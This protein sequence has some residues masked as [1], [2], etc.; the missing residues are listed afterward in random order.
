[1]LSTLIRTQ[2]LLH[3]HVHGP[4]NVNQRWCPPTSGTKSELECRHHGA[5]ILMLAGMVLVDSPGLIFVS[6]ESFAHPLPLPYL[7][8]Q[9]NE[10]SQI[11][12]HSSYRRRVSA[13]LPSG[14][15]AN[16]N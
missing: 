12:A 10:P 11:C 8:M 6:T 4:V 2:Y 3:G 13:V 5:V 1:M 14:F 16:S 9:L 7:L 15:W